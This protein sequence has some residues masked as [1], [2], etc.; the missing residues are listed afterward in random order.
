[1]PFKYAREDHVGQG[2]HA[3]EVARD[4]AADPDALIGQSVLPL[5]QR[6]KINKIN[7]LEVARGA[8]LV[9][10]GRRP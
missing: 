6:T 3:R 8:C 4:D 2:T 9:T 10:P 7:E 1:M 5:V